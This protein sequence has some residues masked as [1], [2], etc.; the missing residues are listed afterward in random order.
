MKASGTV[1]QHIRR[2]LQA[3]QW[4]HWLVAAALVLALGF[5]G[6]HAYRAVSAA[7]YWNY[8]RDEPIQGWMSVGFVAHS[9]H[10][11][12][13]ILYQAI[14]LPPKPD[15]RPLRIIAK[16]QNRPVDA[17]KA[18]LQNAIVHARY[19]PSDKGEKR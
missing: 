16:A 6:L 14:G 5:T 8:N 18:S 7:I 11:P 15:K 19:P 9:Y 3:L 10:V 1:R 4:H 13:R 17:V 2:T 12:P